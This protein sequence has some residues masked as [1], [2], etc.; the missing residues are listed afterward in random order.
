M[1]KRFFLRLAADVI[2]EVNM[3]RDKDDVSFTRK[4]MLPCGLGLRNGV[5]KMSQLKTELQGKIR[6]NRSHFDGENICGQLP[7]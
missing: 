5:R 3:V 7:A 2:R 4:A 6:D 1:G